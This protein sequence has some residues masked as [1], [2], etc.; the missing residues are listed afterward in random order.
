MNEQSRFTRLLQCSLSAVCLTVAIQTDALAFSG[1]YVIGDSL[2]DSGNASVTYQGIV[3]QLGGPVPG[4]GPAIPSSVYYQGRSSDGP[5]YADVLAGKLGL[6]NQA[7]LLGGGNYA[8]GGARTDYQVYGA[9]F[10]GMLDQKDAL[11]AQHPTIDPD[12]LVVVFGGANNIQDL[13]RG[14]RSVGSDPPS[15]LAETVQDLDTIIDSLY[16]AGARNFL[17]PNAPNVGLVPRV[18]LSGIPNA[19]AIATGATVQ[20]NSLLDDM[21]DDQI[22]QGR[23]IYKLDVFGLLQGV[24]ADPA[25][26]GITNVTTPCFT[27]DDLFFTTTNMPAPCAMPDSYLFWDTI[28]PTSKVHGILGEA[29]F[30]AVVPEPETYALLGIGLLVVGVARRHRAARV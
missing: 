17:V 20:L 23:N 1:L 22:A 16:A 28:H 9:P 11:L 15:T 7:S 21:L 12:A 5:I 26:F 3:Q 24:V 27:G 13:L 29:A 6:T 2:S 19:V 4:F 8:Y 30:A 18:A 14:Q 10:K 25:A